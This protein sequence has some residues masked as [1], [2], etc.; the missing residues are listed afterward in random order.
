MRKSYLTLEQRI[1]NA[2]GAQA[3]ETLHARHAYLHA[4]SFG[5]EEWGQVWS[6]S[7]D[8]SWAHS[9]GRMRGYDS[10]YYNNVTTYNCGGQRG[11]QQMLNLLPEIGHFDARACRELAM[12]TLATDIVEVADDGITARASFL[13]PGVLFSTLNANLKCRCMTLWERYGSDF[14]FEDGE[15][16]YLHEQVCPD[17]GGSFDDANQAQSK[18]QQMVNPQAGPG[19]PPPGGAAAEPLLDP[20]ESG[21][22]LWLQDKGPLHSDYTPVQLVQNSVPFPV[23]YKTMDDDNT[24]TKKAQLKVSLNI[25]RFGKIVGAVDI[26][27]QMGGPGGPGG[28]PG[29]KGGPGGAP[30]GKGPG[31][32]GGGPGG[33]GG[34]PGGPG[35]APGGPGGPGGPGAKDHWNAK[36]LRNAVIYASGKVKKGAMHVITG[37]GNEAVIGA[38]A[39]VAYPEQAMYAIP[40]I[41][42]EFPVYYLPMGKDNPKGDIQFSVW[43]EGDN[44]YIE[45]QADDPNKPAVNGPH[46]YDIEK[47]PLETI[48]EVAP[49]KHVYFTGNGQ[50]PL[51]ASLAYSYCGRCKSI[52]MRPQGDEL[53][54]CVASFCDERKVGDQ[55]K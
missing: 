47:L 48:P 16:K 27:M 14:V 28:A 18:Y 4:K 29:G 46:N 23:P 54:T 26:P 25:E 8:T 36:Y 19:G 44:V 31:G 40:A 43:E 5:D 35:G 32:P 52:N 15:W 1:H 51:K 53:Y 13:T 10:V 39:C 17:M 11:Y 6:H 9:F 12:H 55:T 21:T 7:D 24:Y 34:A 49:D 30:E 37:V 50:F 45:Y 20:P 41:G 2:E 22:G 33:P 38:M 3:A 42:K